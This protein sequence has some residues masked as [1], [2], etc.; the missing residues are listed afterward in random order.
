MKLLPGRQ[1]RDGQDATY[2]SVNRACGLPGWASGSVFTA[3]E[4]VNRLEKE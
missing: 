2:N 4:L 3:V 1:P